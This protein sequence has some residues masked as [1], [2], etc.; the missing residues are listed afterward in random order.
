MNEPTTQ[1]AL[2]LEKVSPQCAAVQ[3]ADLFTPSGFE[4]SQRLA[5]CFASSS[6]VPDHFKNNTANCTIAV[7]MA[8][9][10][11]TDILAVMQ[12]LYVVHGK[13]GWSSQFIAACVNSCGLFSP[14]RY[15][16]SGTGDA[17]Q[18]VATCKD[19]AT[20]EELEGPPVSLQMAKDEGWY[21]K[22]G[23]KWKTMPELMLRYRA[24]TLFGR[25]YAPHIMMG[26]QTVEE[27]IDIE[28]REEKPKLQLPVAKEGEI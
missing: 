19:L 14:I 24:I 10:L 6:L 23:S 26:M 20:G 2:P 15:R 7:N 8:V 28:A 11:K 5:K 27:V 3:P 12:N 22:N 21:G 17:R 16:M 4:L 25:L 1:V 9:R 18:C 13:P